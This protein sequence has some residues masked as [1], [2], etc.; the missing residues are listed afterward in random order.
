MLFKWLICIDESLWCLWT[1]HTSRLIPESRI[2]LSYILQK[3]LQFLLASQVTGYHP[4]N[5]TWSTLEYNHQL[6]NTV[7]TKIESV[8]QSFILHK[9]MLV[10]CLLCTNII[11][12]LS[13]LFTLSSGLFSRKILLSTTPN[14]LSFTSFLAKISFFMDGRG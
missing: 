12:M 13:T 9:T 1:R 14:S 10:L 3:N 2:V 4:V 11:N 5:E 7:R 8:L 6:M